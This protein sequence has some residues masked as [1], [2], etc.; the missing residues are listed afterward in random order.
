[1]GQQGDDQRVGRN[2]PAALCHSYGWEQAEW[3]ACLS[4]RA[5]SIPE[6]APYAH[7]SSMAAAIIPTTAQNSEA[8]CVPPSG[9]AD[10][11]I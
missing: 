9:V 4:V 8:Y 6:D 11:V 5:A 3:A 2:L 10:H 7:S 1:M